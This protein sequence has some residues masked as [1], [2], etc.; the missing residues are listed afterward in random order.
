MTEK[1][2][3][4]LTTLRAEYRQL[5]ADYASHVLLEPRNGAGKTHPW[6]I[7][8]D[9]MVKRFQQIERTVVQIVL[10]R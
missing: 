3:S 1:R 6:A 5:K 4:Q 10:K 2:I 9:A 8:H 7:K